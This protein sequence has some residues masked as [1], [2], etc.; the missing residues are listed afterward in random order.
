M[1]LAVTSVASRGLAVTQSTMG[2]PVTA[3]ASGGLA[4]TPVASGGMPVFD[5]GGTLFG[6]A[7]IP[8]NTV[9]PVITG[10]TQVGN[11]LL[12]SSGTWSGTAATYT[13]QWKRG[14]VNIGGATGS[15]YLL[16]SGD[17][18]AM[19]SV[20][21]TAT[22]TAGSASATA[23]AVGPVTVAAPTNSVIPVISGSTVQGNVLTTTDGTWTGSPTFAYQWK[24]GGTN[25]G[26]NAN[27]YTTVVGDVGF[28]IAVVV[29]ATNAGGNA[30]ATATA[31]GP[32]TSAAVGG[33]TPT[34]EI[35]FF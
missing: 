7:V 18:A 30:S 8:A 34:Y 13:Y 2:M 1:A 15:S 10:T 35:Y 4:V 6:P 14:G 16:V 22:N 3:I 28:S 23:V 19:I 12:T 33:T 5:T 17:L 25:V 29:T 26:T 24:R 31:V 11:T 20:T 21:V 27:T 32:I 9:L